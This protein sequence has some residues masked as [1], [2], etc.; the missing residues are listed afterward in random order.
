M[1]VGHVQNPAT[2]PRTI[3]EATRRYLFHYERLYRGGAHDLYRLRNMTRA[4]IY[5]L[6]KVAPRFYEERLPAFV[7]QACSTL[8]LLDTS[9]EQGAKKFHWTHGMF[10]KI[11]DEFKK[12]QPTGEV[13]FE[14]ERKRLEEK[15]KLL[16]K[17][18]SLQKR[19]EE[20]EAFE[21]STADMGEEEENNEYMRVLREVDEVDTEMRRVN[22][23]IAIIEGINIEQEP[24]FELKVKPRSILSRLTPEQLNNLERQMFE[25]VKENNNKRRA[26]MDISVIEAMIEKLRIDPELFKKE[27]L[28]HISKDA[29]DAYKEYFRTAEMMRR[30]SSLDELLNSKHLTPREGEIIKDPDDIPEEMKRKLEKHSRMGFNQTEDLITTFGMKPCSEDHIGEL[31][32]DSGD[33]ED[34]KARIIESIKKKG[35]DCGRVKEEPRDDCVAGE[36][37]SDEEICVESDVAKALV[38]GG[39]STYASDKENRDYED[40]EEDMMD[41]EEEQDEFIDNGHSQFNEEGDDDEEIEC[42]GTVEPSDKIKTVDLPD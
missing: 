31:V 19:K 39:V 16:E 20:L 12:S 27:E 3:E 38:E 8:L 4:F 23:E 7:N 2:L 1:E 15:I 29:L 26:N 18:I 41:H 32:D 37:S 30:E 11:L 5:Q 28:R 13:K 21:L 25:F 36:L 42:L 35:I 17:Q 40:Y 6:R 10:L 34:E 14:A 33:E 9:T 22:I 24:H